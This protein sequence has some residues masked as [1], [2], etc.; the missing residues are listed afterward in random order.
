MKFSIIGI[1]FFFVF[2]ICFS[3]SRADLEKQRSKALKEIEE[4]Q[5]I[6][7]GVKKKKSES[8][9]ALTLLDNKI[10]LRNNVINNLTKDINNVSD[11]IKDIEG[12]IDLLS[13]DINK[14]KS[15]YAQMIYQAYINHYDNNYLMYVLASKDFNQAYQRIKYVQQFSEYRKRQ[16]EAISST[17]SNLNKELFEL[18]KQKKDKLALL[19]NQQQENK[20]LKNELNE[21]S[22]L[23]N[24]LKSRESELIR[25][26]KEK[27]RAMEKLRLEI[28]KL[29]KAEMAAKSNTN[30]NS[31]S[32]LTPEDLIVSTNFKDNKGK[33]P[34]PTERGIVTGFYGERQHSVYKGVKIINNGIDISTVEGSMARA[35]FDGE[36]RYVLPILGANYTVIVRHGNY[37]TLYKNLINVRVKVGEKIKAKQ[38]IGQVFTDSE[39]NNTLLHIEIWDE[40]QTVNPEQ[41]LTKN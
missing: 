8:L 16:V 9:D 26:L 28:E 7:D 30:A 20:A 17:Q 31:K 35:I 5:T 2:G 23:V 40:Q 10:L 11:N 21:K 3:Q 6:L 25:N 38:V 34:W 15:D 4:T 18:E 29:I 24:S 32:R 14:L 36:V 1:L 37:F 13:G 33:L 19:S 41:W 39:T 22:T 27:N 12:Q